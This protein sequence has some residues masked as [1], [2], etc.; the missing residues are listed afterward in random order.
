MA[1]YTIVLTHDVDL[2]G[3]KDYPFFSKASFSFIKHAIF[4]NFLRMLKRDID[5]FTYMKSFFYGMTIPLIKLGMVKDPIKESISKILEIEKKYNVRST[6]YF[7]PFKDTAGLIK[8]GEVAPLHRAARYDIKE[9]ND[10]LHFLETN[11]W[12]VGIHG[13][14]AHISLEEARRELEVFQE[15]F[16]EKKKWGIRMHW[17]YKSENLWKNLKTAGYYYDSTFGFNHEAGFMEDKF[18]PFKKEGIWILPLIIHDV[19]LLARWHKKLSQKEAWK[20]I[21]KVM[22][23]AKEKHAV[24][25]ILWHNCSFAP[26]NYWGDVYEKIIM[27]GKSDGAC[28]KCAVDILK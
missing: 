3:L 15:I 5:F 21:E 27:K 24:L 18:F 11:G 7:I 20:E 19:V 12:E 16:P 1:N 4:S 26:P 9:Y 23:N 14:N 6:F 13:L 17:L 10:L 28:F 25:T 22:E 2:M 8:K